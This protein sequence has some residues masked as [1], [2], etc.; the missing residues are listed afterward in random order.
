M[1]HH[2]SGHF[3]A[4]DLVWSSGG[5]STL[6]LAVVVEILPG[7]CVGGS[8]AIINLDVVPGPGHGTAQNRALGRPE[9]A[10]RSLGKAWVF[11]GCADEMV[12][13]PAGRGGGPLRAPSGCQLKL[14]N[15]EL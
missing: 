2:R 9:S 15:S 5:G 12:P 6:P 3:I 10:P 1:H 7:V 4:Q 13:G 14:L 8:S 11:E